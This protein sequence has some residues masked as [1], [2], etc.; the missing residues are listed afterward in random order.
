MKSVNNVGSVF[1]MLGFVRAGALFGVTVLLAAAF[2]VGVALAGRR[3]AGDLRGVVDFFGMGAVS[4]STM[5]EEGMTYIIF[6]PS[7]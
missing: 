7:T 1:F 3:T 2:L 6:A 5:S 4:S